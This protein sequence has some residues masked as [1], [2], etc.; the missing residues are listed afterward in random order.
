M[1]WSFHTA[2]VARDR[3]YRVH[4]EIFS[5][6]VSLSLDPSANLYFL[7]FPC[8]HSWTPFFQHPFCVPFHLR[9]S[10]TCPALPYLFLCCSW[11]GAQ[12]RFDHLRAPSY[13]IRS[14]GYPLPS[15]FHSSDF[16]K[17]KRFAALEN[18]FFLCLWSHLPQ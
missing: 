12:E 6:S 3:S 16:C 10:S 17:I 18:M 1:A 2:A 4:Q 15:S 8:W 9:S 7:L 11:H 14:Q 13:V 5:F